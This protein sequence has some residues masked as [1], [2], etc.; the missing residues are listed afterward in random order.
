[1]LNIKNEV[2]V[3]VYAVAA[4]VV[5]VAIVIL[6][7]LYQISIVQAADWK[8]KADSLYV[9][10]VDAPSQRGNILADDGSLLATSLPFFDV[11]WDAKA[12]GLTDEIFNQT[13]VDS[14]AWLL[15][16]YI[17]QQYTPG[18]YRDW[19]MALRN[20]PENTR[21]IRYVP[22]A[23]NLPYNKAL[24][25]KT[26]PIFSEGRYKGGFILEQN[27]RRERPF[28]LLAQRTIGYTREGALPVGLE[29]SFNNILE[30][31]PGK[32]LMI[33]VPGDIYIPVNDLAEI[34]PEPGDDVVTTLDINIQDVAEQSL[35]KACQTHNADH[36]CAIVMEV[37]TGKIRAIANIGKTPEGWWETYNYA[38]GERVEPGSMFKLASFMAMLE[39]GVIED[40]D[41]PVPVFGGKVR[42]YDEE[43]IDAV[44]HGLD[45]MTVRQ[46]FAQSSN[47]GTAT[48]VQNNYGKGNAGRFVK[49]LRGFGLDLPTDIEVGGEEAPIIKNPD[50]PNSG[51]SGTT[52]PW[53]SI[54]YEL[55]LTP[56]QLL[57]F[58]NAVANNGRMM[59]PY[60]VQRT[61]RYGEPIR[62]FQPTVVKRSIASKKT[63]EKAKELLKS[64]VLEGT[65][66]NI[67]S[68]YIQMA[69]KT[70]TAQLNYHK[71]RAS[72]GIR[73]QAGFCGFFPA[74]NPV[75]SCIVVISE[76]ERGGY[77]GA[78]VAAPVFRDIAERCFAMK[79]EMHP[80][81]N[82]NKPEK[83]VTR[84]LPS[85][86]AGS[87]SDLEGSLRWL[88]LDYF[89]ET[90]LGDW[91]VIKAAQGDS[92]MLLQRNIS[93]KA[94]PSVIGMGLKDAIYLLEN[95]GCRVKV[96]GVGKVRR[97]TLAPGTRASGQTCVL[98]LE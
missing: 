35:L 80:P 76:P 48:L 10:L 71:F 88:G 44:P 94:V 96:S 85:Y 57:T 7:R 59:K 29:G 58:Y 16:T 24:L 6:G 40:F 36:G 89:E 66:R 31:R 30:G 74:D 87:K 65:A 5:L 54:G 64:V 17:D 70:G 49:R 83:L 28:K 20:A 95:R 32:Q 25:V 92:L 38:I 12:E 60:I 15:S 18:A 37:K 22:I 19:L 3:R 33:R 52:L 47:V 77:H 91:T 4:L 2:L 23:K 51:W 8:A 41:Q 81:I 79:A 72:K 42:I 45:T 97:Q 63:V 53:M 68:N 9:K 82:Q 62:E 90:D 26:F 73:H 46:V 14:L 67:R 75:Y 43:L 11:H 84:E 34:E 86:D 93:D 78:E 39:D 61:E 21:G 13:A 27:P 98:Y 55:L 1:M 56:L 50:D 69:G